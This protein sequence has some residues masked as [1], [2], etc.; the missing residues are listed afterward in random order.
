MES[1][2]VHRSKVTMSIVV[3]VGFL[4]MKSIKAP[5]AIRE[6]VKCP[7]NLT[8]CG[9]RCVD[10]KSSAIACGSCGKSC[11]TGGHCINGKCSCPKDQSV[12]GTACVSLS[13]NAKNC[14]ACGKACKQGCVHGRCKE[15][16][17][18]KV[19]EL[20]GAKVVRIL[21]SKFW[22]GTPASEKDLK[23]KNERPQT[24]VTL[25]RAFW[26]WQSEV[27]QKQFKEVMGY[28]PSKAK[29]CGEKC[30]VENVTLYEAMH[31]CNQL[32]S[33]QNCRRATVVEFVG[34]K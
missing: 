28:N 12:C 24:Q 23:A 17:E 29:T 2:P 33:R 4:V 1:R 26:M 8:V 5:G 27:T 19:D 21:P 13:E 14:G 32:S 34:D 15:D 16:M 11:P 3:S 22:M 18:Q 30:P 7:E 20:T 31:F 9:N 6:F 25:T 10:F